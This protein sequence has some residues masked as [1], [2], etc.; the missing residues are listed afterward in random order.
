MM[1][2]L[3]ISGFA[4]VLTTLYGDAWANRIRIQYGGSLKPSNA[5]DIMLE[6]DVDGG[7]IGGASLKG[8][9]FSAIC[10]AAAEAKGL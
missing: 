2:R 5:K 7:L 1:P 8:D 4:R 9:E 3:R 10:K 6:P